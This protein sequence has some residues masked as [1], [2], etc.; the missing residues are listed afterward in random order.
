MNG[1]DQVDPQ[2]VASSPNQGLLDRQADAG[3]TNLR[4]PEL[5]TRV[6]TSVGEREHFVG[7]VAVA[8]LASS[9][10]ILKPAAVE[11]GNDAQQQGESCLKEV[12]VQVTVPLQQSAV[13]AVSA[14]QRS[15]EAVDSCGASRS[16]LKQQGARRTPREVSL[17]DI[18]DCTVSCTGRRLH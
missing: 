3:N 9:D 15:L 6:Q 2:R 8:I 7:Q 10:D 16:C 4:S 13:T 17:P 11:M 14:N 18:R 1:G 5:A 12:D